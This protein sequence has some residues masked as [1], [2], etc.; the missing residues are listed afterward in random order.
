MNFTAHVSC[1]KGFRTSKFYIFTQNMD[2]E[3]ALKE[4]KVLL[5]YWTLRNSLF[6]PN[7]LLEIDKAFWWWIQQLSLEL[8]DEYCILSQYLILRLWLSDKI[9]K[10]NKN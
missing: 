7:F 5:N 3:E 2:P 1:C 9:N 10:S 6:F 4:R 8:P